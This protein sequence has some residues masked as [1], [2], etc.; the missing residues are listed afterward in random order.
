MDELQAS[1]HW[2]R[3]LVSVLRRRGVSLR[4]VDNT[5]KVRPWGLLTPGEQTALT[6]NREAIKILLR[7][8]AEAASL[9]ATTTAQPR[10]EAASLPERRESAMGKSPTLDPFAAPEPP[11]R[12]ELPNA[13]DQ[14]RASGGEISHLGNSEPEN[15]T[16]DESTCPYCMQSPCIGVDHFQYRYLHQNH[17]DEIARREANALLEMSITMQYSGKR[18]GYMR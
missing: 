2:L 4:L 9:P 14:R 11:E 13:D 10:P 8:E 6:G 5:L 3:A 12:A 1:A 18:K 7:A 16:T 15:E 17:P